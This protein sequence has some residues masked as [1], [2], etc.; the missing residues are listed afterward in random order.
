MN[1]REGKVLRGQ[2]VGRDGLEKIANCRANMVNPT[3]CL[4]LRPTG[5]SQRDRPR[6]LT[7]HRMG[8]YPEPQ[9]GDWVQPSPNSQQAGWVGD[10]KGTMG[11]PAISH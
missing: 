6:R 4:L 2:W 8:W 7:E 9:D 1:M 5:D 3:Q 10:R 11:L